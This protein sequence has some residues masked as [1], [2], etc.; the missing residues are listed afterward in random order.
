MPPNLTARVVEACD[1]VLASMPP[2]QERDLVQAVRSKLQDP[3]RVAIAGQVSGGKST[4]VNA[5]LGQ[6]LAAV[7]AGECTRVVTWFRYD[8]HER[9]EL[10]LRSGK[11]RTV[12]FEPGSWLPTSFDVEAAELSRIEVSLSNEHLRDATIIDTP[13]G[14][15]H[16]SNEA[17]ARDLLG[18]GHRGGSGQARDTRLAMSRADALIFLMPHL[19]AIDVE[20]LNQFRALY[21]GTGLSAINAVAV[22]SKIDKLTSIDQD[23][24]PAA[25]GIAR[26]AR[27]ELRAVVSD[28]I[29]IIGLLAETASTDRFTERDATALERLAELDE[30]DREDALMSVE[31][32]LNFPHAEVALDHRRHLLDMLDLYGVKRC[33]ELIDAK[34]TGAAVLL[35]HL[36]D[37]SG[38][39]PLRSIIFDTFAPRADL[40]KAS[41]GIGD[42]RR[43]S[44]LA[45]D[46]N[47]ARLLR[48]LRDQLERLELDA[49]LQDLRLLEVLQ[50]VQ[51]GELTLP[52]DLVRDVSR[53]VHMSA[54][55]LQV[56]LAAD[57]SAA[58][59]AASAELHAASW[60]ALANDRRRPPAENR[61]AHEVA[62]AYERVWEGADAMVA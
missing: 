44:Y 18:L 61:M 8:H 22:L 3:L 10:V 46:R 9:V 40:L 21:R 7:D 39:A 13:G 26:R 24:W 42:L 41:A 30:L 51:T 17:K 35:R 16:R 33:L 1:D 2:G 48:G 23:P 59:V 47:T 37:A 19:K 4:V 49:D 29:P 27:S 36:G 6:R 38:F 20:I 62:R 50:R 53:L 57:A 11:R 45:T 52:E 14:N 31:D 25:R 55:P 28:V 60:R 5:L 56:G 32:F 54:P 43:V 34:Q 58:E 15:T 12:G